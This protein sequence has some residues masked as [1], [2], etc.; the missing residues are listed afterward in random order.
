MAA[1]NDAQRRHIRSFM[2]AHS[3][4][5]QPW[6][7][8]AGI[9]E[10]TLRNYLKGR[11]RSM[12]HDSLERLAKAASSTVAEMIGEKLQQP[13]PGKDIIAVKSLE[14]RASMGG[15]FEVLD[16]PEGPPFYFRRQWI[17]KVLDGKPG[18]LRVLTDLGGDSMLPTIREGDMGM[19]LL[20]GED[21]RF[22]SGA[23]YALWD[24]QGLL[25]KRLE[26]VAGRPGM[27]RVISDN[28]AIH[29]PYEVS[30]DDVR[31]IGRLIWRAGFL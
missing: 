30:A 18:M 29:E 31:I 1:E 28:R 13:R 24:G 9:A 22:Q 7:K 17:E 20:P 27:L 11:T 6:A 5:V 4:K 25:V 10:G 2:A 8:D 16:E 26:T 14:V 3:L 15:G 12:T 23:V 21:V 19:L